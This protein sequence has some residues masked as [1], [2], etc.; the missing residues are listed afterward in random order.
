MEKILL[1]NKFF[2]LSI[3]ALIAKTQPD[4]VVRW[5]PDGEFFGDFFA[6]CISANRVQH[7]SDLHF[8]FALRLHHVCRHPMRRLR[9][10]EEKDLE[11]ETTG[12]KYNVRICY[13]GR[14]YKKVAS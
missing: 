13:A 1:F 9:I 7:I 8:K 14:P 12:R 5:S 3:H 4:K 10:G 11:E 6:F 2:R